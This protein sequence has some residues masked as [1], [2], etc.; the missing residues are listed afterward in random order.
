MSVI[1]FGTTLLFCPRNNRGKN[2]P[3]AIGISGN[4]MEVVGLSSDTPSLIN[5]R[6][7]L[8]LGV[9]QAESNLAARAPA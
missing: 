7:Q 3:R 1:P 4:R 5:F 6:G 9:V 8:I 2:V